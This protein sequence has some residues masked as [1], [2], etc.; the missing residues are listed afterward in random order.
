M[1]EL[2]WARR[3]VRQGWAPIVLEL[4]AHHG[5]DTVAIFDAC[6]KPTAYI[7]VEADPRNIGLLTNR[8]G[9]RP[10][11]VV[12]AAIAAE[13]GEID[14]HLSDGAA[15]SGSSSIRAPKEH[16]VHF[17]GIKF[18]KTAKVPAL[19]LD[20]LAERYNIPGADLIWCDIQGAERDMIAGGQR[21]LANTCYLLAECDRIEMY[22]GQATRD[23]L[24]G[25]LPGWEL[26]AEWPANANLLLRNTKL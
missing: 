26:I 2:D 19:T 15:G 22:E 13:C 17:P 18:A 21:T 16:L 4:G 9:P 5:N 10:V 1:T 24:L 12:W 14:L 25:L 6:R 7:A 11:K 20:A 3:I 8:I 23:E